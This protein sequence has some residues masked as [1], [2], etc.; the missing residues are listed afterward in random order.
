MH[1]LVTAY[2]AFD[3][4]LATNNGCIDLRLSYTP[5]VSSP[6]SPMKNAS[7]QPKTEVKGKPRVVHSNSP[8]RLAKKV[9]EASAVAGK[10]LNVK[11]KM[12]LAVV[13]I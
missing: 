13:P 6:V 9:V 11:I 8:S 4:Q 12:L 7:A 1:S 3:L 2:S 10:A 5:I